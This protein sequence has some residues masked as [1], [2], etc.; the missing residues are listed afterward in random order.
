MNNKIIRRTILIIIITIL[1]IYV[2]YKIIIKINRTIKNYNISKGYGNVSKEFGDISNRLNNVNKELVVR[3]SFST[4]TTQ[5]HTITLPSNTNKE[6]TNEITLQDLLK[7]NIII[8]ID[9]YHIKLSKNYTLLKNKIFK[10]PKEIEFIIENN[11]TFTNNGII[12]IIGGS[13][14]NANNSILSIGGSGTGKFI[15]NGTISFIGQ[16]SLR[17]GSQLTE[18]VMVSEPQE[19]TG[20]FINNGILN[21]NGE[22]FRI[23]NYT[24]SGIF[25]NTNTGAV[26]INKNAVFVLGSQSVYHNEKKKIEGIFNN[27]GKFV[28]INE[29]NTEWL[30]TGVFNNCGDEITLKI[31]FSEE[32]ILKNM[33]TKYQDDYNFYLDYLN[34]E[35]NVDISMEDGIKFYEIKKKFQSDEKLFFYNKIIN[36]NKSYYRNENDEIISTNYKCNQMKSPTTTLP[37][38]ITQAPIIANRSTNSML[39]DINIKLDF[40]KSKKSI[41]VD[42]IKS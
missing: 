22:Y 32:Q 3:E 15:N 39:E 36:K 9:K 25:N 13:D 16:S 27:N 4:S 12:E 14:K 2:C 41:D 33:Q 42:T 31:F 11:L 20:T 37:P 35:G 29:F 10:I 24:Y 7:K 17:L 38:T 21:F 5:E 30:D 8:Q 18:N 26:N 23:G 1:I 6:S 34:K 40:E 19:G 28:I